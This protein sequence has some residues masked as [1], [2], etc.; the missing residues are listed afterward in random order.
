MWEI[1]RY[2]RSTKPQKETKFN[3][4]IFFLLFVFYFPF[5]SSILSVGRSLDLPL[6]VFFVIIGY[7]YRSIF[8]LITFNCPH[9]C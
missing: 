2:I 4:C 6:L 3:I 5:F 8:S 1:I 9:G 7:L